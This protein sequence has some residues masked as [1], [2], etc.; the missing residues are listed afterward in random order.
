MDAFRVSFKKKQK[1]QVIYALWVCAVLGCSRN[2]RKTLG[3]QTFPWKCLLLVEGKK[4]TADE[5]AA[6]DNGGWFYSFSNE[7]MI[8]WNEAQ[9]VRTAV[10]LPMWEMFFSACKILIAPWAQ[11]VLWNVEDD[12]WTGFSFDPFDDGMCWEWNPQMLCHLVLGW[13]LISKT[14]VLSHLLNDD[15]WSYITCAFRR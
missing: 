4:V 5:W 12:Y 10:L 9:R 1:Y 11:P 6:I 3:D 2:W 13:G 14:L 7:Y 8:F 15:K